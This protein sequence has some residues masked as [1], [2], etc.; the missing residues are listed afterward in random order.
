MTHEPPR[1]TLRVALAQAEL[2]WHDPEANFAAL[3]ALTREAAAGADLVVLPETFPTGFAMDPARAGADVGARAHAFLA[4]CARRSG[5]WFCGST[6][7][8]L[9]VAKAYVNRMLV[10]GPAGQTHHY[11]KRHRF[12]M[13]GEREAYGEGDARPVVVAVRGW[14]ILLQ[15]CYDLRFPVFSRNRAGDG[16]YDL[17]VYVA[18]WPRPRRE[19]WT[20][21]LRARAI[22]NQAYV[23]GV[24]RTG[25]DGNGLAYAGGSVAFDAVGAPLVEL[26]EAPAVRAVDLSAGGLADL[27]A[28]LPFLRDADGFALT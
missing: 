4:G 17:A 23:V 16:G 13:A 1:A 3:D 20:T 27:R 5:A 10:V 18:N 9:P 8:Y 11:D 15:V 28:Q 14:R 22:E 6:P 21:L 24:N 7:H 25:T 2:A 19:H 26:G 12:A